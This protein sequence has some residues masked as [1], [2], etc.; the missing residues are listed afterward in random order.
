MTPCSLKVK[1]QWLTEYNLYEDSIPQ[2]YSYLL[3]HNHGRTAASTLSLL[4]PQVY[5]VHTLKNTIQELLQFLVLNRMEATVA[6]Q[7]N[8]DV[9]SVYCCEFFADGSFWL[10]ILTAVAG[11]EGRKEGNLNHDTIT[12]PNGLDQRTRR[13]ETETEQRQR[14]IRQED[15]NQQTRRE[16]TDYGGGTR[17]K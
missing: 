11:I 1:A 6:L 2:I 5:Q 3:F 17:H 8:D 12:S 14:E 4:I 7:P 13:E 10:W 9:L 15:S 16:E